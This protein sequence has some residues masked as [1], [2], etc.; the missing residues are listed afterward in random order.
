MTESK[1]L[2]TC[3]G[4]RRTLTI[5]VVAEPVVVPMQLAAVPTQVADIQA[6]ERRVAKDTSPEEDDEGFALLILLPVF[7]EQLR[8]VVEVVENIAVQ[9]YL[10]VVFEFL[11][12]LVT[13]DSFV[14]H[15]LFGQTKDDLLAVDVEVVVRAK[16]DFDNS[17][18]FVFDH[19]GIDERETGCFAE[20]DGM[21][22]DHDVHIATQEGFNPFH[23]TELVEDSLNYS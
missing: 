8:M 1:E 14:A 20:I 11:A 12:E 19:F 3:D 2:I 5:P 21:F 10:R 17:P 9:E 18:A 15:L 23:S 16:L 22:D 6:A 13:D 4:S 7:G